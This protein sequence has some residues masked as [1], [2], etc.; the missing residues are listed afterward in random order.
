[1][2]DRE[3]AAENGWVVKEDAGR[4]WR[5]VV[6]SPR[7]RAILELDVIRDLCAAGTVVIACGGGGLPVLEEPGGDL[8]GVEAVIDKDASSSLLA[9]K[10]DAN[11]FLIST[12]VEK[13][14]LHFGQ[15]NQRWLD[16]MTLSEARAL[17]ADGHFAAGS[18]GPK[19]E[20]VVDYVGGGHGQALITDPANLARALVGETGT[21]IVPD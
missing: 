20:A 11:L 16:R 5:R 12:A 1:M 8:T 18:M 2:T 4:G 9:R 14:A 10:M 3:R 17:T 13:V 6:A 15:P 19:I 7:P 21:W